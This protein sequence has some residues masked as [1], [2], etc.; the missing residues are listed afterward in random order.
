MRN[1][2][3]LVVVFA[4]VTI[5]ACS[6]EDKDTTPPVITITSPA[7]GSTLEKGKSYPVIGTITDNTEL[8]EIDAG[9]FKITSFDTK[10][11][12]SFA[13]VSL[14]IPA[15]TKETGGVLKITAKDKAGN[16]ATKTISFSIK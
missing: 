11:S 15:D 14:P 2:T 10:N 1:W 5:F 9:G 13:N 12:Y 8:A 7:D 6:K 4:M 16:V 3:F